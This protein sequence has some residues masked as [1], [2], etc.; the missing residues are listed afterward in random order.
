[1]NLWTATKAVV[2]QLP[3]AGA[4][5]VWGLGFLKGRSQPSS[6][7]P[8]VSLIPAVREGPASKANS[9]AQ[10]RSTTQHKKLP[11]SPSSASLKKL[12]SRS[13]PRAS[14]G[15]LRAPS[16]LRAALSDSHEYVEN[17]TASVQPLT[18]R[19]MKSLLHL[20]EMRQ[21]LVL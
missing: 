11:P 16:R 3:A 1:M 8:K 18:T 9:R 4:S 13:P 5:A 10:K 17:K 19:F 15:P 12:L 21:Q 14:A 20:K 2:S 7:C 6:T